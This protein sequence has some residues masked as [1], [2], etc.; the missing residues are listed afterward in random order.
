MKLL[1]QNSKIFD[2]ILMITGTTL[3]A[4]GVTL[5]YAPNNL[6]TG[7][8]S[9]L[10]IIIRNVS[11]LY[12]PFTIPIWLANI[13]LNAPLFIFGAKLLG[14]KFLRR[15]LVATVYLTAAYYF[16]EFLPELRLGENDLFLAAVF[17]GVTCGAGLGI[18][19]RGRATTG[20]TDILASIIHKYKKHIAL[21]KI[22]F[23]ADFFIIM[24]GLFIFG[25]T[26]AMYAIVAVFI[27]TRVIS[28]ILEGFSFAKAA[29][30]ISDR[31]EEI[32]NKILEEIERGATW[33]NGRGTY[34]G[35]EKNVILCVLSSKEII[36]L[37]RIVHSVDERAFVI[38]T[39]V[40]EVMG[41]GFREAL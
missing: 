40:R 35:K 28:S 21:S 29:F 7:G 14:M 39:D 34:T 1:K 25:P 10:S 32:S 17:G 3:F 38:V 36:E 23:I 37:K 12:L 22:I 5:F 8:V 24:T 18:V 33:L 15:T 20:G 6:I 41:E 4:L 16:A 30:I 26:H 13:T 31:P 9:G 2:Y 19:F 27:S 11:E